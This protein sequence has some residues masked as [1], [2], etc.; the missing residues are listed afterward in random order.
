MMETGM[1]DSA[2]AYNSQTVFYITGNEVERYRA[3][4]FEV[5]PL[6]RVRG[7][8]IECFIAIEPCHPKTR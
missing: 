5:K 7:D 3:A 8:D 2:D 1:I 4:G 6:H